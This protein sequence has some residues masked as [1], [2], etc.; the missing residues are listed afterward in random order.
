MQ[1]TSDGFIAGPNG[2][3]DWMTW[4]W[5]NDLKDYVTK[6][7]KSFD[8]ILMGRKM[9]DGFCSHWEKIAE[10]PKDPE[11]EAA[12][13]FVDTPKIVFSRTIKEMKGKNVTVSNGD[14][15]QEVIK[16][17]KMKGRD[18]I[19]YGGAGFVSNLIKED[20]IDDYHLF[21]NPVAIGKGMTIFNNIEGKRNL[22]L[23]E[24]KKFDCGIVVLH[25]KKKEK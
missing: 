22:T 21:I 9:T 8:T 25:Y 1:M 3:L 17:K 4:D 6:L 16:L 14:L 24:S 15:K 18:L 23:V 11:Y 20:L 10:D 2:E 13:I 7:T 5:D 19:V 12:K